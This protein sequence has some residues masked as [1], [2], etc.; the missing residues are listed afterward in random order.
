MIIKKTVVI[1]KNDIKILLNAA[2]ILEMLSDKSVCW[3]ADQIREFV[4]GR[5]SNRFDIKIE[6]EE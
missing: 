6:W 4:V 5:P 1:E 2:R 3:T